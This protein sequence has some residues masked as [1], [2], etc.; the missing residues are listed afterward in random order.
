MLSFTDS[1]SCTHTGGKRLPAYP[2]GSDLYDPNSQFTTGYC[3]LTVSLFIYG[4][5]FLAVT[6][7]FVPYFSLV[8]C[9]YLHNFI[10]VFTVRDQKG[11]AGMRMGFIPFTGEADCIG[12]I[13]SLAVRRGHIF[14]G[15]PIKYP[16][17][18]GEEIAFF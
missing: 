7:N 1:L 4:Y 6:G 3:K 10:S 16:G 8:F 17:S 5:F 12:V 2:A 9:A 15:R 18:D 13:E 11:Q 14:Y